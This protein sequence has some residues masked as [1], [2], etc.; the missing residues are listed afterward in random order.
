MK[1]SRLIDELQIREL[2]SS[3]RRHFIRDCASGIGAAA[4]GSMFLSSCRNRVSSTPSLPHRTLDPLAIQSPHFAPKAKRV[5]Y[6]HMTGSP[7]QLE[8]FDYKPILN[9]LHNQPCPESFLKGKKFAFIRDK[10]NLLG[11]QATF[12]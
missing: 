12:R 11:S 4:F 2:E 6:L 10:P 5:I 9:K 1:I 7:S 8:L 3:T